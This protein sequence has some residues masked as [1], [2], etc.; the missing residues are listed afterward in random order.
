MLGGRRTDV[1]AAPAEFLDQ[2]A[3]GS[4]PRSLTG[5]NGTALLDA[6][7]SLGRASKKTNSQLVYGT[8][9]GIDAD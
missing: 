6:D 8:L 2:G 1:G 7:L 3:I 4:K 9:I 5:V